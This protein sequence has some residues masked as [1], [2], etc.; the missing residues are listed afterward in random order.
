MVEMNASMI[1]ILCL[2]AT[3]YVMSFCYVDIDINNFRDDG[4]PPSV[5]QPQPLDPKERKRQRDRER[6][7]QME[8][9]R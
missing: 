6:Y 1:H 7:A 3:K 2:V 9:E 4:P 8:E 5:I